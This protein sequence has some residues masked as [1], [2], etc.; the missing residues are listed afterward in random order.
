M[1]PF[2]SS[3]RYARVSPSAE[4][5]KEFCR[6]L[7]YFPRIKDEY[8]VALDKVAKKQK[9]SITGLVNE[10]LARASEEAG[11]KD[12]GGALLGKD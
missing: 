7:V 3:F 5:R 6:K 11:T 9:R 8:I 2:F 10:I 4:N 12:S 1:T